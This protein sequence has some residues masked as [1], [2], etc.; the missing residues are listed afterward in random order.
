MKGRTTFVIAHRLAT[1]GYADRI[2]VIVKGQI[3]EEGTHEA[4]LCREGEYC[5][6]YKMQHNGATEGEAPNRL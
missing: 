1:A 6:L 4:L 3:V 2:I 5:K